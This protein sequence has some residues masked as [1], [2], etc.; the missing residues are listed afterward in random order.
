M[1]ADQ[2]VAV[3][4]LIG[5]MRDSDIARRTGAT[6]WSVR[7]LR[8]DSGTPRYTGRHG[9]RALYMKGRC[10][11]DACTKAKREYEHERRVATKRYRCGVCGEQGH[12]ARSCESDAREL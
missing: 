11:C 1:D 12:N 9:T 4:A 5:R 7:Q 3:R 6:Y 10:R 2:L 8:L